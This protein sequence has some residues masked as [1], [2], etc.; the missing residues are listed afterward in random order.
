MFDWN[1]HLFDASCFQSEI[2]LFADLASSLAASSLVHLLYAIIIIISLSFITFFKLRNNNAHVCFIS[3]REAHHQV[4]RKA[5]VLI[6][7]YWVIPS[8][9]PKF[10]AAT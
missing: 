3:F 2:L 8:S 5:L 7:W 6:S 10:K 4:G 1:L 9:Q